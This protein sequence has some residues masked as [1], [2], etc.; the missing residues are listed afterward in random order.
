MFPDL[1]LIGLIN[2]TEG[3]LADEVRSIPLFRRLDPG[4]VWTDEVAVY[5]H[6][7]SRAGDTWN[8][9]EWH[10]IDLP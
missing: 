3:I 9:E 8:L 2:E 1:P 6:H 7:P 4:A 10:R 5:R